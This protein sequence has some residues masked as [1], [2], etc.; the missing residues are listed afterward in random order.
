MPEFPSILYKGFVINSACYAHVRFVKEAS[1]VWKAVFFVGH[2]KYVFPLPVMC[3]NCF[4]YFNPV[5]C[6]DG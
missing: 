1:V 2:I 3:Y 4:A 5:A 6:H